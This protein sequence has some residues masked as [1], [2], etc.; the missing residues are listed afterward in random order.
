MTKCIRM[1]GF[2]EQVYENIR[3]RLKMEVIV[4]VFCKQW[5]NYM[6]S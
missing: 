5:N 2:E 1:G 3:K 6:D 4:F